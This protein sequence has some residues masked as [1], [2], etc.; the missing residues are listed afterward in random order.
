M[1]IDLNS[2]LKDNNGIYALRILPPAESGASKLLG[3]GG[4][5]KGFLTNQLSWSASNTW[6]GLHQGLSSVKGQAE[7]L[8]K[9]ETL[10]SQLGVGDAAEE[11]AGVGAGQHAIQGI[12]ESIAR[13]T[14]SQKPTFSFNMMLISLSPSD[15]IITPVKVLLKGCYPRTASMGMMEAPYGYETGFTGGLQDNDTTSGTGSNSA[16]NV[17]AVRAGKWFNCPMLVLDSCN[18]NFSQQCTP[19]GT[20]LFAEVQLVFET[21]RLI[22]A[23]EVDSFFNLH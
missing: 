20:P 16:K 22:T 23:N 2:L 4:L 14:G 19:R 12:T 11:N 10:A 9:I 17:W 18:V 1:N 7:N 5:I 13:Y 3:G 6:E 21:W 8:S 15:D